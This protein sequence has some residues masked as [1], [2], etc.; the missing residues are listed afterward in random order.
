V[1]DDKDYGYFPSNSKGS[2]A[3]GL[4]DTHGKTLILFERVVTI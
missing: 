3:H 1:V 4:L 2:R